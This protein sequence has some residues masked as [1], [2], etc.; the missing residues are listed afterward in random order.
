MYER[1][2]SVFDQ[3]PG[4]SS[5]MIS[6]AEVR[7]DPNELYVCGCCRVLLDRIMAPHRLHQAI[8]VCPNCGAI[9]RP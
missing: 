8:I 2:L 3:I 9:N 7:K 1:S 6:F 5:S 4:M